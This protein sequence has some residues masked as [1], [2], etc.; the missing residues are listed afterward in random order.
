MS[1]DWNKLQLGQW[2]DYSYFSKP[3][4]GLAAN[5]VGCGSEEE[6]VGGQH[7][8]SAVSLAV[9][10]PRAQMHSLSLEEHSAHYWIFSGM[11]R[12]SFKRRRRCQSFTNH[13]KVSNAAPFPPPS[14]HTT[15][16]QR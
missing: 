3:A 8:R 10:Q 2:V 11:K 1:L 16:A 9:R 13:R 7:L 14:P 6:V 5:R 15:L 12:K 4:E